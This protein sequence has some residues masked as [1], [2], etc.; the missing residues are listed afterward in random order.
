MDVRQ[1]RH[2]NRSAGGVPDAVEALWLGLFDRLDFHVPNAVDVAASS[3]SNFRAP[4][5]VSACAA[6][7]LHCRRCRAYRDLTGHSSCARLPPQSRSDNQIFGVQCHAA[8]AGHFVDLRMGPVERGSAVF[9]E[10]LTAPDLLAGAHSHRHPARSAVAPSEAGPGIR[11]PT[12]SDSER[13][14][15]QVI[16]RSFDMRMSC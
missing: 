15:R 3:R 2:A 16:W 4:P 12:I 1:L 14:F 9:C 5:T 7:S 6:N 8:W 13:H 11:I 10:S